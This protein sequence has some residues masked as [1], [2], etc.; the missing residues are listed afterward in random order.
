MLDLASACLSGGMLPNLV[1]VCERSK[2]VPDDA[3]HVCDG[4]TPFSGLCF[5]PVFPLG[6]IRNNR[7]P[8]GVPPPRRTMNHCRGQHSVEE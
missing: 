3:E 5:I 1:D 7:T 8:A 2:S 6:F 4:A